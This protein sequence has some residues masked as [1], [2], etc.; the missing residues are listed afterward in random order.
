MSTK[1]KAVET[2]KLHVGN[3]SIYLEPLRVW[4]HVLP[5]GWTELITTFAAVDLT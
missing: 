5:C 4:D 1:P 2:P 3:P